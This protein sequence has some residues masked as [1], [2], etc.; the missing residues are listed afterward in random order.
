MIKLSPLDFTEI[1]IWKQNVAD[2]YPLQSCTVCT[3][4]LRI[5]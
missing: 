2:L 5:E 3:F 1:K 4:S